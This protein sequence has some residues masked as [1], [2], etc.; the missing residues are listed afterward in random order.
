MTAQ[1]QSQRNASYRQR[2]REKM[3]RMEGALREIVSLDV[4][5]R[6][7]SNHNDLIACK[8][9]QIAVA[10]IESNAVSQLG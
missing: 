2:Q 5:R 6:H 8:A 7:Q 1:T 4:K 9:V 10:A 3:A